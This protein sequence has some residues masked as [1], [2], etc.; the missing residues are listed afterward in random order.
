MN[1]RNKDVAIT[2]WAGGIGRVLSG[3]LADQGL[4]VF[5][6]DRVRDEHATPQVHQVSVD[7]T[8]EASIK[9][10]VLSIYQV[11]SVRST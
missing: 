4:T 8:S 2:G 9:E 1:F 6:L 3:Y 7:V 11:A 10:A 5:G